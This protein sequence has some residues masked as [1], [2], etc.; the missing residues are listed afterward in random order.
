MAQNLEPEL[1]GSTTHIVTPWH[2]RQVVHV[3]ELQ[4][5]RRSTL[6]ATRVEDRFGNSV[7]YTYANA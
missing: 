7:E 6:Y 3:K 2:N 4:A 5:R 1:T